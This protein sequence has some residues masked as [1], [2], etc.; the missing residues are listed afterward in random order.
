MMPKE[1]LRVERLKKYFPVGTSLFGGKLMVKAVDDVS[2]A[3]EE[4]RTLGLVGESG[5]GKTTVGR[6]ILRLIDP[7]SGKVVFDGIDITLFQA[8]ELNT[9]RR[10][11]QII[12]QNP[13][14]TLNPRMRVRQI[15]GRPIELHGLAKGN[16]IE[17]KIINLLE[18]VRLEANHIDRFPHEFSG[19]QRQRIAI[20]RALSVD[21]K[22]IVLDEPTSS[23]AVSVQA[24]ILNDLKLLQ[25]ET[26]LTFLFISHSLNVVKHM[27]HVIAVMYLGKLVEMAE[28]DSL[29]KNPLH[30][31]TEALLAAIP[32]PD[33]Q[34]RE[35]RP[36]LG[37]EVPSPIDPPAG[38]RFHPRCSKFI[39]VC[40]REE[41]PLTEVQKN[42][43]VA[44]HLY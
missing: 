41:P 19:G 32:I 17:E 36:L 35:E 39:D 31:Y 15:V 12:F 7:T 42:H 9:L 23:L 27:S 43:F 26:N 25:K 3:C 24:H 38:C 22:F 5:C 4:G 8:K 29:F 21:P 44:C 28:T 6:T 33:P 30:P 11:A 37:G 34:Q 10:Q 16:E 13:Y 2:F 1:L 18:K 40:A 20:A 14:E